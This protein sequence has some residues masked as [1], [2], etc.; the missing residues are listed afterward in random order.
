M[1]IDLKS[2]ENDGDLVEQIKKLDKSYSFKFRF[3][4]S[5][6]TRVLYVLYETSTPKIMIDS[7]NAKEA[8][9][10]QPLFYEWLPI[11]KVNTL[12]EKQAEEDYI[13][14]HVANEEYR[15]HE[16]FAEDKLPQSSSD[17][18]ISLVKLKNAEQAERQCQGQL[19]SIE[20]L[21]KK[22]KFLAEAFAVNEIKNLEGKDAAFTAVKDPEN[23]CEFIVMQKK[24][25]VEK[26][27]LD[28]KISK[29]GAEYLPTF[30]LGTQAI[31]MLPKHL[32]DYM[33]KHFGHS[34]LTLNNSSIVYKMQYH[35]RETRLDLKVQKPKLIYSN[36]NFGLFKVM[37]ND[38]KGVLD[39]RNLERVAGDYPIYVTW[40]YEN[41][42]G[43][44]LQEEA[45]A[46]LNLPYT[47]LS[48]DGVELALVEQK[49][50]TIAEFCRG[51]SKEDTLGL[52]KNVLDM[53]EDL[54]EKGMYYTCCSLDT[55]GVQV[56]PLELNF[57]RPK[58]VVLNVDNLIV[59]D[60]GQETV[61]CPFRLLPRSLG[62][63]DNLLFDTKGTNV[64]NRKQLKTF[65]MFSAL[66][67][68]MWLVARDGN[69]ETDQF[70]RK[71]YIP[72]YVVYP[73]SLPF[74]RAISPELDTL[75]LA[76]SLDDQ[77]L[78]DRMMNFALQ[79]DA[80]IGTLAKSYTDATFKT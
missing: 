76:I 47:V 36:E 2:A 42:K 6:K 9:E 37:A 35:F 28:F 62:L 64:Y 14:R 71:E 4:T 26:D 57:E 30:S 40:A 22:K 77:Q 31:E 65:A 5:L 49:V 29:L 13:R 53:V 75:F 19:D 60:P 79:I 16:P 66:I 54:H 25:T 24:S 39:R 23:Q 78:K 51:K 18:I 45:S 12:S 15:E 27:A 33:D 10:T 11:K 69:N 63:N 46:H 56:L 1:E 74:V 41:K 59:V 38:S 21:V 43:G 48:E 3:D 34:L 61:E 44:V 50:P 52:V 80:N 8:F 7:D 58:L 73:F 32:E 17:I 20:N 68:C 55:L 67:V 70:L 72:R